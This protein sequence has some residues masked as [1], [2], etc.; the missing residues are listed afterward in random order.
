VLALSTDERRLRP[1]WL[2]P[3]TTERPCLDGRR[4]AAPRRVRLR[5]QLCARP[6][7]QM[8]ASTQQHREQHRGRAGGRDTMTSVV[9]RG[10]DPDQQQRDEQRAPRRLPRVAPRATIT[11]TATHEAH[12][13]CCHRRRGRSLPAT[14]DVARQEAPGTRPPQAGGGRPP[15]IRL[16]RRFRSA[17]PPAAT[18]EGPSC[19]PR[20]PCLSNRFERV[21]DTDDPQA[22]EREGRRPAPAYRCHPRSRRPRSEQRD[23]ARRSTRQC[24]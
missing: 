22:C 8:I 20:R 7:R 5:Q 23:P 24:R 2:A 9:S 10:R 16:S 13:A 1:G 17:P 15:A 11:S 12:R 4:G 6:V 18:H 14:E 19:S 3:A 21:H